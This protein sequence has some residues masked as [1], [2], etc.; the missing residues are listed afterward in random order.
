[1]ARSRSEDRSWL[2]QGQR[3]SHAQIKV[4]GQAMARSR[5]EVMS[6]LAQV[7][8][9][10]HAKIKVIGQ[11]MPRSRTGHAQLK[12]G[13]Q[14]LALTW[15]TCHCDCG[16]R[17]CMLTQTPIDGKVTEVFLKACSNHLVHK[18]CLQRAADTW[19]SGMLNIIHYQYMILGAGDEIVRVLAHCKCLGDQ[20]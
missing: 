13:G 15:N 12:V 7:Q 11:V 14:G 10:G 1:M 8:S 16:P 4:I 18:G 6:C 3:T 19:A 17:R 20:P 2:D 5:S 9:T